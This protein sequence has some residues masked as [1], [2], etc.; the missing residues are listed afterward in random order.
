M[1]DNV[2]NTS[3]YANSHGA[4]GSHLGAGGLYF[5]LPYILKSRICVCL[6]SGAGF[7]PKLMVEAQKLLIQEKNIDNVSVHLVDADIGP[8]GRPEY[9]S[10]IQDYPEINV[11]KSFTDD[12]VDMFTSINYLHVDADHSYDQVFADLNNYGSK[13]SGNWAI[14]VHDTWNS[15]DGDHPE[16]GSFKAMCD[17]AYSNNLYCTNF[18]IGCGTGLIMPKEVVDEYREM[19]VSSFLGV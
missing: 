18:Q 7:V 5:I 19:G 6:G 10:Q 12:A 14:T 17:Y 3:P 8:W 4:S 9:N 2:I 1:F 16:I 13:M 11:V 15:S